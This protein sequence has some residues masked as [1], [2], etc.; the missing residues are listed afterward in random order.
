MVGPTFIYLSTSCAF[1]FADEPEL[2]EGTH[3]LPK[4]WHSEGLAFI[5][6]EIMAHLKLRLAH[7]GS[8]CRLHLGGCDD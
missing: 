2:G 3:D 1:F 8:K 4:P 6:S 5:W 7:A